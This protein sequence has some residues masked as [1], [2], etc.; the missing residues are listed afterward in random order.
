MFFQQFYDVAD[1]HGFVLKPTTV[2]I[3][4]AAWSSKKGPHSQF[5]VPPSEHSSK[6]KLH[7]LPYSQ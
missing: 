1:H 5:T 3:G 4:N 2:K 7:S 6:W